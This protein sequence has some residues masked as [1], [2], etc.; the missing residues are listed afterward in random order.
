MHL[1]SNELYI[2]VELNSIIN[3]FKLQKN[4]YIDIQIVEKIINNLREN[5]DIVRE[6]KFNKTIELKK[7]VKEL[8]KLLSNNLLN[9]D[10]KYYSL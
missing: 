2:I 4:E 1:F 8:N 10:K 5:I 6:N 9:K 3:L 7:N